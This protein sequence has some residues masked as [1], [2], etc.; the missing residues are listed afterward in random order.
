MY[1][2]ISKLTT[3][4]CVYIP[5]PPQELE[6]CLQGYCVLYNSEEHIRHVLNVYGNK[7][8]LYGVG[9]NRNHPTS[10]CT[11]TCCKPLQPRKAC[12][13][14]DKI[15]C[16]QKISYSLPSF[17]SAP[18]GQLYSK[19]E[20]KKPC[21]LTGDSLHSHL[22]CLSVLTQRKAFHYKL[23]TSDQILYK[24]KGIL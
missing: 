8:Q 9:H 1:G 3:Q 22:Q 5:P 23:Y 24:S 15:N 2:E 7:G 17:K 21:Y 14:C 18:W 10:V 6:E 11:T 19:L 12:V 16:I 20:N 4:A 13:T